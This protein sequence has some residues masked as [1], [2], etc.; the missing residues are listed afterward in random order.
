MSTEVIENKLESI[1]NLPSLPIVLR[2][3]Q[4]VI[5]N[6]NSSMPQIA[7]IVAKDPALASRAIRLVNSAFYG[8]S[9]RVTSIPNAIIILGLNTLNSLM[10]GLTVIKFFKNSKQ[11][12]FD[13]QKFWEHCFGT[14]LISK[15]LADAGGKKIDDDVFVAGLLHDAGRLVL[16]QYL[17]DDFMEA[18]YMT[19]STSKT[20]SECEKEVIGF[21]H[22]EAGAWLSAKWGLP[23]IFSVTMGYHHNESSLPENFKDYQQILRIVSAANLLCTIAGIGTSGEILRKDKITPEMLSID[24]I[25]IDK[26][27]A[28]IETT[29]TELKNTIDEWNKIL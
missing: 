7:A 10:I 18:V 27:K 5:Y 14:A 26:I 29:R 6:P 9:K 8:L 20:L 21:D 1:E 25:G 3:L 15:H 13:Q 17:H 12:G 24:G 19:K 23:E 22:S 28:I 16:D 11:A 2:Q 4:K